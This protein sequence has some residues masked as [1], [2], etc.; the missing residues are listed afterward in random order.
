[1]K[2]QRLA[3]LCGV[4]LLAVLTC[5]CNKLKAR[6]QLNK[7]V[8]SFRN[9]QYQQAIEHFQKAIDLDPNLM[10]ARS[11]LATAYFQLYVPS[12]DSPDNIK[13]GEQTIAAFEDV[14]KYD[15]SNVNAMS[16]IATI[17][18]YMHKFQEA[19]ELQQKRLQIEPNN[20]EGYY[21]IGQL[22]WAICF[23]NQ[24]KLRNDL[25]LANPKDPNH[26]DIL[27]PLPEKDRAQLAEQ[28]GA[29]VDEG[30]KALNKAIELKPDYVDAIAYLN[31]MY[32]QKADLEEDPAARDADVAKANDLNAQAN[33]LMKQQQEK[34]AQSTK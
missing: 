11:Y 29:L 26:P 34:A 16:S 25:N 21:W 14:L 20:P 9:A 4:L 8:T 15:P 30:I 7:G 27:P 28:N 17:D 10:T 24:M 32:R 22:D 18:Y 2:L 3:P 31:L 19:K 23:P 13:V 33:N 5:G 12:G 1:M 6:D